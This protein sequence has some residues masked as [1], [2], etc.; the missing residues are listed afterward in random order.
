MDFP[1]DSH[2][3]KKC[4]AVSQASL[5]ASSQISCNI[6]KQQSTNLSH[7]KGSVRVEQYEYDEENLLG[8]GFTSRVYLGRLA[9]NPRKQFAI[10]VVD[11]RRVSK[12]KEN[13]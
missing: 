2:N 11:K 6:H 4:S 13:L 1:R 5:K 10:K 9:D 12:N 8:Q 7:N 3:K